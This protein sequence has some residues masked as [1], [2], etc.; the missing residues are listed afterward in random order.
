MKK[1]T[2]IQNIYSLSPTQEGLLFH[3]QLSD[4]PSV[5]FE[6]VRL[7]LEGTIDTSLFEQALQRLVERHDVLRTVFTFKKTQKPRQIVLR[8]RRILLD[9]R[10]TGC[11]GKMGEAMVLSY[12]A[13]NSSTG[14]DLTKDQLMRVAL[15]KTGA[16]TYTAIWSFPHIIMDGWCFGIIIRDFVEIYDCLRLNKSYSAPA[17]PPYSDYIAWLERQNHQTAL[18]FWGKYLEGFEQPVSLPQKESSPDQNNYSHQQFTLEL[19]DELNR[20]I[21]NFCK[22]VNVTLH[23][24]FSAVWG[25]VL[26]CHNDSGDAVF[27]NVV[28][29]RPSGLPNSQNMVGLFINTLP[30]RVRLGQDES[31][32]ELIKTLS[33]QAMD[34]QRYEFV[35]LADIQ[36][37]TDVKRNV[38]NHIFGVEN[39]PLSETIRQTSS[40][41]DIGFSITSISVLEQTS[42]DLN[43]MVNAGAVTRIYF[44]YNSNVYDPSVIQSAATRL[45]WL[46]GQAIACPQHPLSEY[47]WLTPEERRKIIYEFNDTSQDL[48]FD[49][50]IRQRIVHFARSMGD[51]SVCFDSEEQSR[52]LVPFTRVMS[53]GFLLERACHV[54]IRLKELGVQPGDI[55]GLMTERGFECLVGMVAV[56]L[57]GGVLLPLDPGMPEERT[58]FTLRDS[59]AKVLLNRQSGDLQFN[60]DLLET[61]GVVEQDMDA[62]TAAYVIY[63]SGS[64]G[65]PKGVAISHGSLANYLFGA[66]SAFDRDFSH[67]DRGLCQSAICFD[68]STVEMFLPL[69]MGGSL[70]MAPSGWNYDPV[71]VARGIIQT[72]VTFAM[73]P[74]SLL[75][76]VRDSLLRQRGV[77]VLG[78]LLTGLELIE[79]STLD[80]FLSVNPAIKMINGY[81][82]TETTICATMYR[83]E[84]GEPQQR[85]IPIGKPMANVRTILLD[86]RQRPVPVGVAGELYIGGSGVGI[87]YLNR[88]ELTGERFV[89][90]R[91]PEI[92]GTWYRTGDLARMEPDGNIRFLGRN[93]RQVK[94]R[95]YRVELEEIQ[96]RLTLHD[97]VKDAV[98]LMKG[99]NAGALYLCAYVVPETS[100]AVD[101]NALRTFLQTGLPDYMVPAFFV[102]IQEIPLTAN[103]KID[104]R[105]LPE[106][107]RDSQQQKVL[108]SDA[109]GRALASIWGELLDIPQETIGIDDHFFYLG[110][111][112]LTISRMVS[113]IHQE[114]GIA[115]A[116]RQVMGQPYIRAI[117]RLVEAADN[118]T[119]FPIT[120]IEK[121][122]YYPLSQSQ[123]SQF[124]LYQQRPASTNYNISYTMNAQGKLR[125]EKLEEAFRKLIQRHESL[126]TSF[127]IVNGQPVQRIHTQPEFSV[128]NLAGKLDGQTFI[129]PFQL[130]TAPLLRLGAASFS[131]D[132]HVL[133]LD[134]HHIIAD[135]LSAALLI[136]ECIDLY[137]GKKLPELELQYK[138]FSVWENQWIAS[139]SYTSQLNYWRKQFEPLPQPLELPRDIPA[140]AKARSRLESVEE[141]LPDD[142][143]LRLERMCRKQD[144]TLFS[145]VSA[146]TAL[147]LSKLTGISDLVLGIPENGRRHPSLETIIGMF[148]NTM[149][150]RYR[151]PT[152]LT[153]SQLFQLGQ[154]ALSGALQH[155]DVAFTD[156][157]RHLGL[158]GKSSGNPLFNVMLTFDNIEMPSL[159]LPDLD[160]SIVDSG[161]R[162][163]K[164]DLLVAIRKR[165]DTIAICFQYDAAMFKQQTMSRWLGYFLRMIT[166]LTA[167]ETMTATGIEWFD[168]KEKGEM[169]SMLT[170]PNNLRPQENSIVDLFNRQ[171]QI[172]PDRL[173]LVHDREGKQVT[174]SEMSKAVKRLAAALQKRGVGRGS[175]VGVM[176]ERTLEAIVSLFA[177]LC[178][179]AAYLPLDPSLPPQRLEFMIKDAS[180]A[181]VIDDGIEAEDELQPAVV[182]KPQEMAYIMYTSG[183]TGIP[184]AVA[185]EHRSVTRVVVDSDYIKFCKSDRVLQLSTI[186]FD[187]SVF[188]IF[189]ALLN[190]GALIL[191][192]RD[193]ILSPRSLGECI[194]RE[195]VTS[196]FMTAALFNLMVEEA[197]D[198]FRWIRA[199]VFGGEQA[200]TYHV[201]KAFNVLGPGRLI[202]GYGP[203]E[204]TVFAVCFP[205]DHVDCEHNAIPIGTPIANTFLRIV[206]R[207][208]KQNPVGIPGELLIGGSGLGRGYTNR[209][210]LTVER[211]VTIQ[212]SL[213]RESQRFYRSG[214]LVRLRDDGCIEFLG[215][216]D[217]QLKIRGFRIEPGEIENC[218]CS[219]PD[220]QEAVVVPYQQGTSN[221]HLAAYV[222][223]KSNLYLQSSAIRE[224]LKERLPSYMIPSHIV[225]IPNIPLTINGKIDREA[226]PDPQPVSPHS[227]VSPQS[228]RQKHL[229]GIWSGVL[230]VPRDLVGID[231]DFFETGGHS[232][233]AAVLM[234]RV[235]D[236]LD[237]RI[238]LADFWE[239]PTIRALDRLLEV[240]ESKRT[241]PQAVELRKGRREVPPIFFI[242]AGSGDVDVYGLLSGQLSCDAQC[243]GIQV[244]KE[245]FNEP[246][247][248]DIKDMAARYIEIIRECKDAGPYRLVGWC[249]GGTIAF[250]MALQL[251]AS[252]QTVESLTLI[253]SGSPSAF[254]SLRGEPFTLPSEMRLLESLNIQISGSAASFSE[255]WDEVKR[256]P[257]DAAALSSRI[258]D[259]WK[260][261][262][263]D[264]KAVNSVEYLNYISIARS[265]DRAR[266]AYIPDGIFEGAVAFIGASQSPL[267]NYI[268][269]KDYCKRALRCLEVDGDHF[270]I[271][272]QSHVTGLAHALDQALAEGNNNP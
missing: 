232:L 176:A 43:I 4:D 207:H 215:R 202:N 154:T 150:L 15:F 25:L 114:F 241:H 159:S 208:F 237:G 191:T 85:N 178:S 144:S 94:I 124:A 2:A 21:I 209:Q 226:L 222:V 91:H 75:R 48:P 238:P 265:L 204:S 205:V 70:V 105:R 88:P 252:G 101:D 180:P 99:E 42:Y 100:A 219:H 214:D 49:G 106:P 186:A 184:K 122:D 50:G 98:V 9:Y 125:R 39:F 28:A 73:I 104:R 223:A 218:L 3:S 11:D 260:R 127:H 145:A 92:E 200:S 161:A 30:L 120:A 270:T 69:Y 110:G 213:T 132:R 170:G 149:A 224:F 86:R 153:C 83:Y 267:D 155:R 29:G 22:Q 116:L 41:M 171:I 173:A 32:I 107:G 272:S 206:D 59:G 248:I 143:A 67:S 60:G 210:D 123:K 103:G 220:I 33:R 16:S 212:D 79:D 271:F 57:A 164:F 37:K 109:L 194:L 113:R 177:I 236:E 137:E 258:P 77:T 254:P 38:F 129:R 247:N 10:E 195:V 192:D 55:A 264:K 162:D 24:F 246:R 148:V 197:L 52:A 68:V 233:S 172:N 63:T 26:F 198:S 160:I 181:L 128:E 65:A 46:A 34:W 47:D 229:A 193:T 269:W 201:E 187:G 36:L 44:I 40:R 118:Q 168:E 126:R 62:G 261:A 20:D 216:L 257:I 82:P 244:N 96:R 8:Q 211:F 87:G 119:S 250:E 156:L 12:I 80:G 45:Q 19:S 76:D 58:S 221:T 5:Y 167:D 245:D 249:V 81:G 17:P 138:D 199:I 135:G 227:S 51:H 141:V 234:K 23:S 255:L 235:T 189:G 112:S 13:Q 140:A 115:L 151:I 251:Q 243:W 256:L 158:Q 136:K 56:W 130:D 152:N 89:R 111:H 228:D 71:L 196:F 157:V 266:A 6:Q 31:F 185:I 169:L 163:V 121:K 84:G 97:T 90:I 95:G 54:V 239:C 203:T 262:L 108:P 93:D 78:K 240:S 165:G 174:Y 147:F 166:S 253:N 61:K 182:V 263:P 259:S 1:R 230:N 131:E 133:F 72:A 175:I 7:D 179:G 64:T 66:Y 217:Q 231:D 188:D 268:H 102:T 146:L 242:H 27:G 190:G 139:E 35:S 134:M 74:P 18:N 142:V 117:K 225:P 183:S 14:F 53:Y